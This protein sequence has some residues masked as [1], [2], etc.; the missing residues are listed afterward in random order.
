M[1]YFT[2][3]NLQDN[4]GFINN[5]EQN[6]DYSAQMKYSRATIRTNL[7]IDVTPSTKVEV[8]L[9]GLLQ[10]TSRPGLNSDNMMYALY[11]VPS[12][13]F[14]VKTYDGIWG[15]SETWGENMNPA[16]LAWAR[17]YSKSHNR[18]LYADIKLDQKLDFITQGLKATV[19]LG[20][21]NFAAYWEGY[22]RG[23]EYAS[24][25]VKWANG[26]PSDTTRFKGGATSNTSFSSSLDSQDRHYNIVG[27]IDYS[28]TFGN[29]SL[30]SSFIY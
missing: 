21:D 26:L 19:R 18:A 11:T 22:T 10:E 1:R 20:Y 23:Y 4:R 13:A 15:G 29:H 12:A 5:P 8:G 3:L 25:A 14:P 16:A 17:G 24:D 6:P 30:Y 27:S 2:L 9:K 7:D 28:K